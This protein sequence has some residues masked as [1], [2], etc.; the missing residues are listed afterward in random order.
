MLDELQKAFE[1][2]MQTLEEDEK[3]IDKII[4][5]RGRYLH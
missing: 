2:T 1:H 4:E 5:Q 3:N